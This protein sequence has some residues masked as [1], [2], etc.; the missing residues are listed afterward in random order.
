MEVE[1]NPYGVNKKE[2]NFGI[3]TSQLLKTSHVKYEG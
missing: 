3:P 1:Q 2:N